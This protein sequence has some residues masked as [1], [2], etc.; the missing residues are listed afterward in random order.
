MKKLITY[1]LVLISV[2]SFAC[3]KESETPLNN[4]EVNATVV[5]STGET[6]SINGKGDNAKIGCSLGGTYIT[7][8][9]DN[10]A[11]VY[12]SLLGAPGYLCVNSPG[13]YN[14]ECQYRRNITDPN[15][16]VW[17]NWSN[18]VID[19]GSITFTAYNDH[20]IEGSFSAVA[21]C[22]SPGCVFGVDSAIINGTFKKNR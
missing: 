8:I 4:S 13:T 11:A 21:K 15:T 16:A 3:K 17:S 12:I 20:Y 14:F 1:A 10:N 22:F 5:L 19:K 2:F 18:N 9:N 7:S 6:I